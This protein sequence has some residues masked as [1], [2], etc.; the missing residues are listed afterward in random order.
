MIAAI[1]LA[2]GRSKRMG[3]ENKL[4]L[5]FGHQTLIQHT[6]EIILS[7][8]ANP[9]YLVLGYGAPEI[10]RY[11]QGNPM[12][13]VHNPNWQQGMTT[14]I[15]AGVEAVTEKVKG[16]MICLADLPLMETG[17]YNHLLTCFEQAQQ[18]DARCIAAPS[19][20]GERGNPVIFS[21]TWKP[22]IMALQ[23]PDGCRS[24]VQANTHH[25]VSIPM[26]DNRAKADVDTPE[27]Y[28]RLINRPF[29]TR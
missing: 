14:S 28:E 2:A 15:Q 7:S 13:M 4:L 1:I 17:D 23:G 27:A 24:I 26:A 21:S 10:E 22:E 8:N 20:Q 5:P 25:L 19:F 18:G 29:S 11:L 9:V 3:S 6:T 16:Y 12:N